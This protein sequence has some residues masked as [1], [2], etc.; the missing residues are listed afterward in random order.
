MTG[1]FYTNK[2]ENELVSAR[3]RKK[4][5][6]TVLI[7]H[8]VIILLILVWG[9]IVELFRPERPQSITVSLYTPP[10]NP[11]PPAATPPAPNVQPKPE[12]KKTPAPKKTVVKKTVKTTPKKTVKKWKPAKKIKIS[13]EVVYVKPQK[14][15]PKF[16][17]MSKQ[18]LVKYLNQNRVKIRSHTQSSGAVQSYENSVG[19]Y[20]YQLW[21]TPDKSVLGGRRPEVKIRLNIAADG[22]LLNA[23]ILKNSGVAAMD[24]SVSELLRKVQYL[25]IP[26]NG[27]ANVTLILEVIE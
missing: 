25:P 19:A 14:T 23:G 8:G 24:K 26:P 6:R 4:I 2:E 17:P 16:T 12:V 11:A 13:K 15:T 27:A 21:E 5:F 18:D 3:T 9:F 1:N 22:R 20:L 10:V 7:V